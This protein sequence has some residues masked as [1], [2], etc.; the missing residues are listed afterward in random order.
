MEPFG[1]MERWLGWPSATAVDLDGWELLSRIADAM[2][3]PGILLAL[4]GFGV[5]I[6]QVFKVKKVA[7]AAKEAA[8]DA[9]TAISRSSLLSLVPQLEAV[10]DTLNKAVQNRSKSGVLNAL[11]LWRRK[12]APIRAYLE[13]ADA[14]EKDLMTRLQSTLSFAVV[15][16]GEIVSGGLDGALESLH[17]L[18]GDI[19]TLTDDLTSFAHTQVIKSGRAGS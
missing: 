10:E 9:Q 14:G 8:E 7:E 17:I 6:Y 11:T 16:R 19:S 5:T 15:T 3:V 2:A 18:A 13:P 1:L 4:V 12:A